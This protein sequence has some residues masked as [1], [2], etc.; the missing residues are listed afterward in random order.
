MDKTIKNITSE[1]IIVGILINHADWIVELNNVVKT[2]HFF[3]S[4]HK[5]IFHIIVTLLGEG[6]ETID[7]M[8]IL[9]RAEKVSKGTEVIAENG[10]LEYLEELKE[11]ASQYSLDD[12]VL[13]ANNV[14]LCA[15]KR[16]EVMMLENVMEKIKFDNDMEVSDIDMFVQEAHQ[17]IVAKY[18]SAKEVKL[19]GE[20]FDEIWNEIVGNRVSDGV[21]GL[22]SKIPILSKYFTYENGELIIIGARAKFGKSNFSL[23]EAHYLAVTRNVP[24][25]IFDTEMKTRTFLNRLLALDSGVSINEIKNGTYEDDFEKVVAVEESKERI[26]KAPL[27]HM[28]DPYWDKSKI[29]HKA[30]LLKLRFNIGLL[31]YDYVKVPEVTASIKEHTE[32]GNWTIFLKNLAGELDIP[33][34]SFAQLSPHERRLADSDKINRY[35]STIAYL[36]PK[37]MEQIRNDFG[38]DNG[39]TAFLWIEYNRNGMFMTDENKGINLMYTR[40]LAKFEQA[41]YQCLEDDYS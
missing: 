8:A 30:K 7:S 31:I 36:L 25:A 1:R 39:G 26:R 21:S 6:A 16:E 2:D 27:F 38:V 29:K 23:N 41:P 10:G 15:F 20:V 14:M 18:T 9:A 40:P 3:I 5:M 32:L 17:T 24:V 22:P 28:Y 12:L 33:I 13:H 11:L 19:I 4:G 37:S 34:L 35:A